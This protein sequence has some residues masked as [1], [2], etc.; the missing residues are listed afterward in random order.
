MFSAIKRSFSGEK[1]ESDNKKS[2]LQ[3]EDAIDDDPKEEVAIAINEETPEWGKSLCDKIASLFVTLKHDFKTMHEKLDTQLKSNVDLGQ[4]FEKVATRVKDIEHN[5][6]LLKEENV[7]LKEKL[8]DLEYRQRCNNL[9]F[10]GIPTVANES[11]TD[12]YE[13][14][15][16]V[17][18]NIKSVDT[19]SIWIERCHRLGG[20]NQQ[21]RSII[22][23]FSYYSD[24]SKILAGRKELP[25]GV[26]VNEDLPED[27]ND[28][29]WVLK[30]IFNLAKS[31]VSDKKQ[32]HWSKDK[33]VIQ[34]KEY[35]VALINNLNEL[36]P[37][38]TST[39]SSATS[40]QL[41]LW[42]ETPSM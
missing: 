36:P 42:L 2:K 24:V 18:A 4:E 23:C 7:M 32:V 14:V 9:I 17:I 16:T 22:C 12:C 5:N 31:K 40:I 8:L 1:G 6:S 27:W 29:R 37:S 13:K 15:K 20:N 39:R 26:Y 21:N 38:S 25:K 10:D 3:H 33:L 11:D 28:R 19:S 30:P 41:V 35:T 34:G